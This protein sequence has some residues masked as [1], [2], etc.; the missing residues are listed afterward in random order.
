M[1]ISTNYLTELARRIDWVRD[2]QADAIAAAL[3]AGVMQL[4][5]RRVSNLNFE[6]VDSL[7]AS[8]ASTA[9]TFLRK[10]NDRSAT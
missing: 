9:T 8:A 3:L 4:G 2:T 6:Q 10:R 1:S 5:G 7:I